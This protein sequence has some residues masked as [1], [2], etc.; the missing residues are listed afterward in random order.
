VQFIG[1]KGGGFMSK[2]IQYTDNLIGGFKV[3]ADFLPFPK[4]LKLKNGST[5]ITIS[6]SCDSVAY[7]KDEAKKIICG[8][9]K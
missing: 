8:T 7:F 6:L 2:Q 4:E 5:K 9:K 1:E 3:G